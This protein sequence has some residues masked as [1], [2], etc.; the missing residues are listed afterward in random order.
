MAFVESPPSIHPTASVDPSVEL[1]A[2]SVV[3][4]FAVIEGPGRLGAG[5]WVGAHAVIHAWVRMGAR[6]RIH[7]HAVLGGP[8]Q[9]VGFDTALESWVHIGDDNVFRE[10]STVHRSK[11]EGEATRVGSK[12]Y[13]MNGSHIGHD[14]S[15]GDHVIF[16]SCATLG[17]HVEV[18]DRA[19]FGGGAMVHQFG[20]VGRLAM[21]AGMIGVRKDVLP[22]SLIGGT[23]VRHYRTNRIGLRRAGTSREASAALEQAFRRLRRGEDLTGIADFEAVAYLKA[24]LAAPSKRGIYGFAGSAQRGR[25]NPESE[26]D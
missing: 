4:P 26:L 9:D 17:G 16:A 7:P 11:R 12:C 14:C 8:P 24:W 19:F 2:N 10:G 22:F 15:V 25:G 1:G 23:P 3:G 6:N 13:L 18:G 5:C 20:R 21:V